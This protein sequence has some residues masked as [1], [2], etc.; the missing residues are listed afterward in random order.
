VTDSEVKETVIKHSM[1]FQSLTTSL[2]GIVTELHEITKSL[3]NVAILNEKI[4]NMDNNITDSF[5]RVHRRSDNLD[6][7]LKI[8]ETSRNEKGCVAL[9]TMQIE[10]KGK[11][12]QLDTL[13]TDMKDIKDIPNKILWRFV[14]SLVGVFA[15]SVAVHLGIK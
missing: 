9:N 4:D 5:K 1:E 8:V 2:K 14:L 11:I 6:E 13:S 15:I 12:D 3:R 7:R 10:Y